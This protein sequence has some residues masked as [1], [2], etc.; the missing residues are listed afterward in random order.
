MR[1]IIVVLVL[2]LKVFSI[3]CSTFA[4]QLQGDIDSITIIP[5]ETQQ[6]LELVAEQCWS[7]RDYQASMFFIQKLWDSGFDDAHYDLLACCNYCGMGENE[8]S[9][10][11]GLKGFEKLGWSIDQEIPQLYT[12]F[13]WCDVIWSMGGNFWQLHQFENVIPY[14]I[15]FQKHESCWNDDS[16]YRLELKLI[17]L[18]RLKECYMQVGETE[19]AYE[20]ILSVKNSNEYEKVVQ[21]WEKTGTTSIGFDEPMY[22]YN[23]VTK[24][25]NY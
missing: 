10:A 11:Y 3:T 23:Y 16:I 12:E 5:T 19:K 4:L 22:F 25:A 8:K 1:K 6:E 14:L 17:M 20:I 2:L 21:Y 18:N 9:L 13:F 15:I 7:L 24:S